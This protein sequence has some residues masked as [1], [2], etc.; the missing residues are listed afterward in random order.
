MLGRVSATDQPRTPSSTCDLVIESVVEDLAVKKALFAELEQV[1]AAGGHLRHQHLDPPGRRAG[2][3][4]AAAGPGVRAALLQSGAG[5]ARWWRS[6]GRSRPATRPWSRCAPSPSPATRSR[7]RWPTAPGSWSTPCSSR[8]STT[9]CGCWRAARRRWRTSTPPCRAGATSRWAPSPC[10]T[11]SAWTRRCRILDALYDEFRDPNYAAVPLLRRMVAA[12]RLGRKSR[13]G[14]L[15]LRALSRSGRRPGPLREHSRPDRG[16]GG[17][18]PP[19][20]RAAADPMGVPAA[21]AAD[22]TDDLVAIGGDLEPGT[23]LRAY[24][25]GLFPMHVDRRHLGW[26]SPVGAGD[27]PARHAS[28][29]PGRCAGAAAGTA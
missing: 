13:S 23:I 11:S 26:W 21:D 25:Q 28:G 22:G 15:L 3:A 2:G 19:A 1:V 14:L 27:H 7:S 5:D 12:G 16:C 24:R 4:D 10:S 18:G 6:C 20:R 17:L 29:R 9:R 8:T